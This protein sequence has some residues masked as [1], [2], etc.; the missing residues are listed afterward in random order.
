MKAS[1]V[2]PP[3]KNPNELQSSKFSLCGNHAAVTKAGEIIDI[4]CK[5]DVQGRYVYVYLPSTNF[6]TICEVE[7]YGER[8]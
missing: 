1:N 5:K 8:T 4:V 6:L 7:V 3:I 2:R